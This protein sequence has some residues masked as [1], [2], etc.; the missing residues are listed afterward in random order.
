MTAR[1]TEQQEYTAA[2]RPGDLS[3]EGITVQSESAAEATAVWKKPRRLHPKWIQDGEQNSPSKTHITTG[4][5]RGVCLVGHIRLVQVLVLQDE[6]NVSP[7]FR[8]V[9]LIDQ[10]LKIIELCFR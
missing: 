8:N 7:G 1:F 5:I 9:D 6:L 10:L 3:P 4:S 2:R